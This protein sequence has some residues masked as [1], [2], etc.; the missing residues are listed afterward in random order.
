VIKNRY[1]LGKVLSIGSSSEG[2]AYYVE[3][4]RKGYQYPFKL[5][6][7]CGFSYNEIGR[8]L[9]N[10]GISINDINAVL[11]THEHNDHSK[12]VKDMVDRGKLVFAPKEVFKK[13]GVLEKVSSRNIIEERK[14]K[15]I[16][17]GVQVVGFPLE[18]HEADGSN[19]VNFGYIIT[20][21]CDYGKHNILFVTDTHYI[22][23]NLRSYKFHT[24]FIEANNMTRVIYMALQNA[25]TKGN[26]W[27]E[28]HF[29]RVLHSHMLAENCAKTLLGSKK[30]A[31]FD[32]SET[33][34]IYLTH[35]T[36]QGSV[37]P[38]EIK[39]FIE[40]AL[41][42]YGVIRNEVRNGKVY[43]IPKVKQFQKNGEL[44]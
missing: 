20:A 13:Y 21:K 41:K 2:N 28:I 19:V 10:Y 32:L 27:K 22:K 40:K 26:K 36:A 11:V 18:H 8:R 15:V 3:I 29:D 34:M 33:D 31:G 42:D 37:N 5:L 24:I 43:K 44:M 12:A 23:Y 39:R 7:E 17:D 14:T 38:M 9:L 25:K 1:A 35:M 16:A 30:N 4:N 6:I